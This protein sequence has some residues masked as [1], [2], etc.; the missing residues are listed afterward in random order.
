MDLMEKLNIKD[1]VH[2]LGFVPDEKLNM[3]YNCTSGFVFPS[4]YEGFGIPLLE[5]MACGAPIITSKTSSLLEIGGQAALYFDPYNIKDMAKKIDIAI[6]KGRD[7]ECVKLGLERIK[8]FSWDKTA[9][10]TLEI[11]KKYAK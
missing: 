1:R 4:L 11:Y 6:S 9:Q 3:L 10:R 8:K 7:S 2:N 5:A